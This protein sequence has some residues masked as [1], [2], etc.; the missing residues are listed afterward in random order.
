MIGPAVLLA[1][2]LLAGCSYGPAVDRSG[3]ESAA[4]LGDGRT[5][6]VA[7]HVLRYRPAEGLAAF[8]D[9][10]VPRYL[11]DRVLLA[12]V[13]AS[14]G[15]P[16]VLQRL[17][18]HGV[19]G[20]MSVTLR[21]QPADPGRVLVLQ[22]EQPSTSSGMSRVRWSRLDPADGRA[23]P[24][25]DLRADLQARGAR[26]GSPE[27]GDVR[28]LDPQGALLIGAQGAAGDELW[29]RTAGGEYRRIDGFRHF[30]GVRGDELYY[31]SGDEAV[32]RN[33]RT[34]AR[35]VTAR[36]NP[37]A[38]QTTTLVRDNPTVRALEASREDPRVGVRVA[39]TT[40]QLGRRGSGGWTYE[41]V[42]IDMG[43]LQMP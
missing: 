19:H 38:R 31:W 39:H 20:S 40:V 23:A 27:F 28:V 9:G 7:Y 34:G 25:P 5:L 43:P 2:L 42:P 14:G 22:S 10:G 4:L 16:R 3:F 36:Y 37:Q 26:L 13:P 29:L 30:Y 8:P 17:E 18:T 12:T 21:A 41:A 11:D 6:V 33:W 24:Y 1:A 32:V 15:R 35:I